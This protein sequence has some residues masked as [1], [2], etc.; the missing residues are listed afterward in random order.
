MKHY[1]LTEEHV[2]FY[3]E[4]GYVRLDNVLAMD[5]VEILRKAIAQA[6]EDKNKILEG[7]SPDG[8]SL[9]TLSGSRR[10]CE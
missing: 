7:F 5:E 2:H 4:N 1:A 8:E 9:G 10:V 6:V 3:E